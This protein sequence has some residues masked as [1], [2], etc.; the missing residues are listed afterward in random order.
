MMKFP[1]HVYCT[2]MYASGVFSIFRCPEISPHFSRKFVNW[3]QINFWCN[4]K[5]FLFNESCRAAKT[6]KMLASQ[7]F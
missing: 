4:Y 6:G 5:T 1:S 3:G 2:V 7:T